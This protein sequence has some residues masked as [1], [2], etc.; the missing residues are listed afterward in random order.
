MEI[1]KNENIL[2]NFGNYVGM[3]SVSFATIIC[4]QFGIQ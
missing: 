3:W 2:K 4:D 1:K